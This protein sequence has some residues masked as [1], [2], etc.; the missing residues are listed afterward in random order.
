METL[1][2]TIEDL[3][4]GKIRYGFEA[5]IYYYPGNDA[6]D[7]TW[8]EDSEIKQ[9]EMDGEL[10]AYDSETEEDYVVTDPTEKKMVMDW[11]DWDSV[12]SKNL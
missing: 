10:W 6:L 4:I 1:P 12:F 2:V 5:V 3:E 9:V 8:Q 7:P 11:V